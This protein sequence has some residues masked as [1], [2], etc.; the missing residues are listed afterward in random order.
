MKCATYLRN[1]IITVILFSFSQSISAQTI[2]EGQIIYG[3]QSFKLVKPS[4]TVNKSFVK[5]N[6]FNLK[7]IGIE[8]SIS[9]QSSKENRNIICRKVSIRSEAK[10]TDNITVRLPLMQSGIKAFTFPAKNG[11]LKKDKFND[12]FK[13]SYQCAGVNYDYLNN[14]AFPM[15]SFS[16]ANSNY[17]IAADL[18]FSTAFNS[19]FIEWT[20]PKEIGIAD[21]IETRSIYNIPYKGNFDEAVNLYYK[22]VLGD[23]PPGPAWT[24]EIAMVNYDYMSD[25][26]IGWY[27]DIDSLNIYIKK[28]KRKSMS[29][30]AR[31][32]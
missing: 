6:V 26:A 24:H 31:L 4:K 2:E 3:G 8:V 30:F 19:N 10:L 29:G 17:I 23:V 14:L 7:N 25:S 5:I 11:T 13:A 32:V 1:L 15:V 20:Y 12:T 28:G 27:R 9:Y 18:Y 16:K 21:A 22:H